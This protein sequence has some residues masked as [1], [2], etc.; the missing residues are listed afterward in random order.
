[1]PSQL[2]RS[3][4]LN[5]EPVTVTVPDDTERLLYVLHERLAQ[6]GP[7]FG[8]GIA[9]CGACTVLVDGAIMRSCVV[10]LN[11]VP[12]GAQ[13]RTLDGLGTPEAPHPM[14]SAFVDKQ[15]AQCAF[16]VNGVVMGAIGWLEQRI[17]DGATD[18]P[19]RAEIADFLSGSL[20]GYTFN[21]LCRCGAHP[22]MLDAIHAA[23][24]EMTGR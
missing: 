18:A 12:E 22:R 15:A 19:S 17:A 14:Q 11:T 5:G 4:E 13:V 2:V 21:Y 16:C 8:C 6:R 1:M 10:R 20:P 3:F 24:A 23:A 9:Q 7:R